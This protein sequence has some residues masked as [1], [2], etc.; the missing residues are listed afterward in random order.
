[1]KKKRKK[2]K[3]YEEKKKKYLKDLYRMQ[4]AKMVR[5]IKIIEKGIVI[6]MMMPLEK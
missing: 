2:Y 5:D 1:M 4:Q 3:K 6:V